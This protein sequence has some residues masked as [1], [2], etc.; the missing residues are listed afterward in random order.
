MKKSPHPHWALEHKRPGSE[1]RRINGRYY[2]YEVS[3][4]WDP[5][6]KRAKKVTGKLLGKISEE[7]G[8]IESDKNKLRRTFITKP[9]L[10]IPVK[11]YGASWFVMEYFKEDLVLLE[12][13]FPEIWEEIASMGFI[14]LMYNAP[15]KNMQFRFNTS[16][17]SQV[18]SSI[19]LGEKRTSALYRKIG[20]EREA[21]VSYM[22]NYIQDQD[23]IM[24]DGTNLVS[25]SKKIEGA[26]IGYNSKQDYD[27]QFN[28]LFLFSSQL[29]AP[30]FY[31]L[32]PGNIRDVKAFKLTVQEA[33]ISKAIVIA[34]KG[35]Y[36]K[37]NLETLKSIGIKYIIPMRRSNPAI[38][39]S[40]M[41]KPDN[42]GF[43]GYFEYQKRFVW[44][45]IQKHEGLDT[46]LF[47]D[48]FLKQK[49]END[50]LA[51]IITH[52]E[53]YSLEKYRLKANSFGTLCFVS[54]IKD[55]HAEEIYKTYKTRNEIETMIDA[56]KNVL[57]IDN[58][59]MQNET[60][61]QGW[62][63]IVFLALKWYYRIFLML[64]ESEVGKRMSPKDLLMNLAEIKKIRINGEWV[65][66]EITTKTI[67]MLEKLKIHIT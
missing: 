57:E 52:P 3:S 19:S 47:Y 34:D 7:E 14:R 49:E 29:K 39:Y 38:D 30:V 61:L 67:A 31:R 28:I 40:V 23:H 64:N 44:Y 33:G 60:A 45:K 17:L 46:Y 26:K 25:H 50:Y 63:F 20:S 54:N 9:D 6:K 27:P 56:M 59:Y 21:V 43:D 4:K 51:R 42:S 22:K 15:I 32:L 55:K 12:K 65:T 8:F 16:Y 5:E 35:F 53:K 41:Q 48:S 62:M 36:S 66:S 1:L 58:S 11:E 24:F 10:P 37:D 18:F 2:L 13:V